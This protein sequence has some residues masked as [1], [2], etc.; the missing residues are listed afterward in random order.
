MNYIQRKITPLIRKY[1]MNFPAVAIIGPR[2]S[3]KSTLAKYII[4][5][6]PGSL[7]LDLENPDDISKLTHPTLFFEQY[8]GRLIC[9]DEIQRAPD[10][11][12]V[13]RSVIDKSGKNGQFLILGSASPDLLKQSNETLAGRIVYQ[14]LTP[15]LLTEIHEEPKEK[16]FKTYWLRGG[17]PRSFS[18]ADDSISFKWRTSFIKSFL[19]RDVSKLGFGYPPLTMERLWKMLAHSQGQVINLTQLGNSLGVSHTMIRNYLELLQQTFMV[20]LIAPWSGNIKKRLVRTPKV[21]IRDSGILHALMGIADFDTLFGHP[22]SGNSWET[23][24]IENILGNTEGFQTS[25]FRTSTGDEIDLI[26]EKGGKKYAVECKLSS[27]P[28]LTAGFY[29]AIEDLDIVKAW[30][31]APVEESYPVKENVKVAPVKFILDELQKI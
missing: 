25:F 13:L 31:A 29:R 26:L 19:E 16:L 12:Q 3:G 8:A 20:Q 2:Q 5:E 9:L 21:Y 1:L 27:A 15:F 11:F 22:V 18:A 4:E 24:V 17:F 30:I 14:E 10:L 7:Y 6:L 28:H 23:M